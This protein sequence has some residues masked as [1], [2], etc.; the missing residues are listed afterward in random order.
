M[1]YTGSTAEI[2][3]HFA[4]PVAAGRGGGGGNIKNGMYVFESAREMEGSG[5]GSGNKR[6]TRFLADAR[7][8]RCGWEKQQQTTLSFL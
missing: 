5:E 3:S 4:Y 7:D 8:G 6:D 2:F 1:R